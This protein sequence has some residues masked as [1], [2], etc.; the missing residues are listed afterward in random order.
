MASANPLPGIRGDQEDDLAALIEV[1]AEPATLSATS[2]GASIAIGLATR[3]PELVAR[4][5]AHEPPLISVAA[6]DHE[7]RPQLEAV[8][9]TVQAVCGRVWSAGDALG[10]AEQFVEEV[11]LGPGAWEPSPRPLRET[12]L[13]GA[14]AFVAEQRDQMWASIDL[15]ELANIAVPALITDGDASPPWFRPITKKLVE[16]VP[17]VTA[18]TYE[19]SGH[20]PHLTHPQ[21]YLPVVGEFLSRQ[22]TR[23]ASTAIAVS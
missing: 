15:A 1:S 19:G 5:I 23:E 6:N 17:G 13:D 11:A 7:V 12:M 10:A 14:L 8:Q 9:A 21:D 3:R 18:H 22:S 20:A 16:A 4:V 2:F